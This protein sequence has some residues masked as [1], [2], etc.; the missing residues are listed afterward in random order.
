MIFIKHEIKNLLI[1]ELRAI[2]FIIGPK[3]EYNFYIFNNII[4][5]MKSL[6]HSNFLLRNNFQII[7]RKFEWKIV[8]V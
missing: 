6:R 1:T 2:K 4:R 8:V 7:Y 5:V 3:R